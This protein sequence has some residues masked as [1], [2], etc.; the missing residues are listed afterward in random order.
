MIYS[1]GGLSSGSIE[2]R[3]GVRPAVSLTAGTRYIDGDG[4]A[5]NPFVIGD[6]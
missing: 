1:A 3:I 4:T 2:S 5:E 6:E